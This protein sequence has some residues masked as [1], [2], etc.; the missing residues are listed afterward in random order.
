[1]SS[2]KNYFF[3][4]DDN[5]VADQKH[6]VEVLKAIA[7]LKIKWTGQG[8][9][10][11]ARNQELLRWLKESGCVVMLIGYESLEEANLDQMNK[12]W[13]TR[14]GN[15]DELTETLHAA[16]L[17]IYA[18]FVFGFDHDSEALFHRT[19]EFAMKH[20]FFFAAF[21]HL[22]PMPGTKLYA[23]LL[24]EGK[25]IQDK[26]WLDPGYTYGKVTFRPKGL[27]SEELSQL[28]RQARKRFYAFPSILKRSFAVLQRSF[29]PLLYYYFW[30]LN[31]KLQEEVDGKLGLPMGE[32]L[33][34]LPK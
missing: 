26:W 6:A 29:D 14:L 4:A 34:E 30:F 18:T 24:E 10:T 7:P 27:S 28:C 2:G 9:L 21:N 1:M 5:F 32:G 15:V 33:D 13:N 17:N 19:V 31:L 20:R 22:L 23:R 3:F 16:G 11:M 12:G 25:I 8:S